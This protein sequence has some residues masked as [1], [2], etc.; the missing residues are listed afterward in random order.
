MSVAKV[1]KLE[2]FVGNV[3]DDVMHTIKRYV[4]EG[5]HVRRDCT[6]LLLVE[7]NQA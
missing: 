1:S 7:E 3:H 2:S 5:F 4:I 6:F